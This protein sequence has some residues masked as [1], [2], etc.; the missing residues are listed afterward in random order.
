MSAI[1]ALEGGA[2]SAV[3][4]AIVAAAIAAAQ[5]AIAADDVAAVRAVAPHFPRIVVA[6]VPLGACRHGTDHAQS[7]D[8]RSRQFHDSHDFSF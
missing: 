4:S 6:L 5:I 8:G 1:I 3:T 7:E 2:A